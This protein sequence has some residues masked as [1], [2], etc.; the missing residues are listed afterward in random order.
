MDI[1]SSVYRNPFVELNKNKIV[2]NGLICLDL[3]CEAIKHGWNIYDFHISLDFGVRWYGESVIPRNIR[4]VCDRTPH[5][6]SRI[7]LWWF[8]FS[9]IQSDSL[10]FNNGW[11]INHGTGIEFTD[12]TLWSSN[13]GTEETERYR[14]R[15]LSYLMSEWNHSSRSEYFSICVIKTLSEFQSLRLLTWMTCICSETAVI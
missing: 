3:I 15:E 12:L 5:L 4:C 2:I 1:H 6:F 14:I 8:T 13:H 7:Y 10:D 9:Y 11:T